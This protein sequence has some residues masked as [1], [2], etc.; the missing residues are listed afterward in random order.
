MYIYIYIYIY[1]YALEQVISINEKKFSDS[2]DFTFPS[3]FVGFETITYLMIYLKQLCF[4]SKNFA[5]ICPG[6]VLSYNCWNI[7]DLKWQVLSLSR[8]AL[9]VL[10][11][12][13]VFFKKSSFTQKK[14]LAKRAKDLF[15]NRVI[16]GIFNAK[17]VNFDI[18]AWVE[19]SDR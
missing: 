4:N 18:A 5:M 1:I 6:T 15:S 16:P 17:D 12:V 11:A 3:Q 8:N 13:F 10:E 19:T 9:F 2:I 14:N 7:E